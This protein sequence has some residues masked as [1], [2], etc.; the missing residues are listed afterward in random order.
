MH[1][2][3]HSCLCTICMLTLTF[4]S[5]ELHNI[6]TQVDIIMTKKYTMCPA[7]VQRPD[8]VTAPTQQMNTPIV[9]VK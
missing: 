8:S 4:S 9:A 2:L 1:E 6:S 7:M 5:Q 3:H